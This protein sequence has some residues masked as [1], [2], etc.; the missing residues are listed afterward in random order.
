MKSLLLAFLSLYTIPL[1]AIPI[2]TPPP[3]FRPLF[4]L[5]NLTYT[6]SI[7]YSTPAHLAVADGEINFNVSNTVSPIPYTISCHA[8]GQ[9]LWDFFYGN[10][11]Y[12]CTLPISAIAWDLGPR[13]ETNFTFSRPDGMVYVNQTWLG[14][15]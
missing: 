14:D 6:S 4:L 3:N 5:H 7:V 15:G 1:H 11:V 9:Q 10:I 12:P 2:T 13:V 8:T